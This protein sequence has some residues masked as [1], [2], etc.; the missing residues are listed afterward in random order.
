M[1]LEAYHDLFVASAGA[2]AAL[3]GLLF[4]AISFSPERIVGAEGE[5]G[6]YGNAQRAFIALVNVFF[7]SLIALIPHA[8]VHMFALTAVVM[9][10]L[11]IRATMRSYRLFPETRKWYRFGA[12]SIATYAYE[13]YAAVRPDPNVIAFVDIVLGLYFYSLVTAWNLVDTKGRETEAE[14]ATEAGEK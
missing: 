3:I 2:A 8:S 9:L 1:E 5:A 7:V 6:G 10:A 14:E 4:V 11:S 12:I 13:F